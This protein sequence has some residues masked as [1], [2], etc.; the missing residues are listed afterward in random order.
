MVRIFPRSAMIAL[1]VLAVSLISASVSAQDSDGDGV[2]NSRDLCP[3]TDTGLA[4]DGAGC[5]AYCEVVDSGTDVFLRSRLLEVGTADAGS[6]GSTIAP[7]AG[8]HP[9]PVAN[10]GF[11]ADPARTDWVTYNGDFFVPGT[12]E[13]GF[14]MTVDGANYFNSTLMGEEGI[15]GTFTGTRVACRTTVCGARGGGSVFW[16]GVVDGIRVDQVYSV[17][18]E[19]LFILAEVTL[20]NTKV[21]PS[22]V[23]YMRNVDP[24]N[25]Q[26][27]TGSYDTTNTIVQQGTGLPG[28][29]AQVTATTSAPDSFIALISQD[30]DARVTH[31]GFSNRNPLAV[32]TCLGGL[33]CLEGS[34]TTSDTAISLAIQKIIPPMTSVTFSYAYTLDDVAVTAS[35]ACTAPSTCGDGSVDGTEGC[36]DG[37]LLPGDGCGPFCTTEPGYDCLGEPSTCAPICGNGVLTGTETCD[38]GNIASGDGCSAT[39]GIEPMFV[40]AGT[41]SVCG[42]CLDDMT[43]VSVDLGCALGIPLCVGTGA[44]AFCAPCMDDTSGGTDIGCTSV[45]PACD[46]S[47]PPTFMCV[48][49]EDTATGAGVDNGCTAL[50]P[51]CG[52]SAGGAPLC[53]QCAIDDHCGV[54]TVCDPS[55]ACVPGCADDGDCAASPATPICDTTIRM[56]AECLSAAQ[57]DGTEICGPMSTCQSVDTDGD[58]VPDEL[59]LDDDDDGIPDADEIDDTLL[60]DTNGNGILDFEDAA[61]VTCPDAGADGVCDELPRSIDFDGDG[62]ANHLDR[63]ADGDG[64]ADLREGGGDD[65]DG[66][67]RV[68]GFTDIDGD[69]LHDAYATTPLPLPDTDASDSPDFLDRDADGD[70]ISDTIEGGGADT[71]GDGAPDVGVDAD[72]DG[73]FDGLTGALALGRRDTDGDGDADYQDLDTDGDG[74][75]DAIEGT[76][77]DADGAADTLPSGVDSDDDG[78]DDA[79][80]P[81]CFDTAECG[82]VVGAPAPLPNR[83]GTGSPDWRDVDSDGDGIT[84]AVECP[85]P[86]TCADSDGD[87]RPDYLS[88]DSDDD[89]IA[90]ADEGHDTDSDGV[91]DTAPSGVDTDSDGLDDAFDADCAL[92]ADCG[93]VIGAMAPVADLDDDGRPNF[94]D[95]DDDGDGMDT[96][97]EMQDAADY[98]GPAAEPT[99]IDEDGLPNWYDEDT[100][101]D[102]ASDLTESGGDRDEDD[103]GI[104]DYMDPNFSPADTDGDGVIDSVECP[105]PA[106]IAAGDCPD[107]D[108]DGMPDYDDTDDDGDGI[109]TAD[110]E[111]AGPD[112]DGDGVPNRLDLDSDDDGILDATE[113]GG[114]TDMDGLSDATDLDADGDGILDVVEGGGASA[115]GNLDGRIDDT[116]DVD[117]NGV[118]DSIDSAP[119]SVPDTDEDGIPDFQDLD[120]DGDGASDAIEGHDTNHDG[121]ADVLARGADTNRDGIDDAYDPAMGG[122]A[123]TLPDTDEDGTPDFRD[124]D[125]DGDGVLTRFEGPT[126]QD[127]DGDGRPDYLDPD[128]DGDGTPTAEEDADPNGDGDPED[129]VDTDGD[130]IPD[131]LDPDEGVTPPT[132][133][134][135][136]GGA[137]CSATPGGGSGPGVFMLLLGALGF[138]RRRRR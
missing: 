91:A 120:S 13:E 27:V 127:T 66:N 77:D 14:G 20:T 136:S 93:G 89:G 53:V 60:G 49:C 72:L 124:A 99:D 73:L 58:M 64:I 97:L 51:V 125:D 23:T 42:R 1:L 5:D 94:Q 32:W 111:T 31:G 19:G 84:D 100:D 101:D 113:G 25:M 11:V 71:D 92:A 68:D 117:G 52:T 45:T 41:P 15:P 121:V 38:D 54:G 86:A 17:L 3:S 128:D 4:V 28:S 107:T 79:F 59:D 106:S 55:G 46:A 75:S 98:T 118:A 96:A 102:G 47:M 122:T 29:I 74:I 80:D 26:P 123:A 76:D 43:G 132:G 131:Y 9:R 8:W 114:D 104:L 57:C 130:G 87:G 110:E 50:A 78:I 24:D 44:T 30:P 10:L 105:A 6:F 67:G 63:D 12:P 119:L 62:L 116:T 112:S 70:G 126:M 108:G 129:A 22:T 39:C 109:E 69:G 18:N 34:S 115:D 82:G 37:N 48:A 7:P 21:V 135:I 95:P 133:G 83:D 88:L 138:I 2:P 56:C 103:N 36:D 134:G 65:T 40:C 137:L 85:M 81:D 61:L 35:V 16:S 33:T 90:D